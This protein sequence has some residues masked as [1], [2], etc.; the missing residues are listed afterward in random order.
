[1]RFI[2]WVAFATN[3]TG[4]TNTPMKQKQLIPTHFSSLKFSVQNVLE[5]LQ[6]WDLG[7][8]QEMAERYNWQK[9][10]DS[11]DGQANRTQ[12]DLQLRNATLYFLSSNTTAYTQQLDEVIIKTSYH[13]FSGP[14]LKTTGSALHR[15][16]RKNKSIN[17]N[18]FQIS[19]SVQAHLRATFQIS[20]K[21]AAV[22]IVVGSSDMFLYHWWTEKPEVP[23]V[24]VVN[25]VIVHMWIL[26]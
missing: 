6:P 7:A 25:K 26:N 5:R 12:R 20:N 1:M 15:T 8:L 3:A 22:K 13:G 21:I 23:Y 17:S 18:I 10:S 19:H 24:H 4:T 9:K 11:T 2:T 14:L 16:S